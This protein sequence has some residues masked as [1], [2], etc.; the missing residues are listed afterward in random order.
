MATKLEELK[1]TGGELQGYAPGVTFA[2]IEEAIEADAAEVSAPEIEVTSS[3]PDSPTTSTT[4]TTTTTPSEE[5]DETPTTSVKIS[6]SERK[7]LIASGDVSKAFE[8]EKKFG[9]TA[10]ETATLVSQIQVVAD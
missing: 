10:Q 5:S 7:N 2:D 4:T 9:L 1:G 3:T 6:S 8:A